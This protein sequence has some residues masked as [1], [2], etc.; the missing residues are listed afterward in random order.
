MSTV[1]FAALGSYVFLATRLP[2]DLPRAEA[3]ARQV[4]VDLDETCSR[5]REDSDLSRV[6]RQAGQWVRVDPMLVAAVRVAVDAARHTDGLVNPLLGRRL[7]EL[8]YDRDLG[9]LDEADD[10]ARPAA[11]PPHGAYDWHRIELADDAIRIPRETALDLGATAKAWGADLIAGAHEQHLRGPALVSL[12]GDIALAGPPDE[13]WSIGVS[14]HPDG[15]VEDLITLTSGGL[16]TSSTRVRRWSR[17]GVRRHHLLDPRTSQPA[18]EVWTTVTATG[19]T[20][21]AA[22][23]ASTA[24]I[25]LG[26]KAPAWLTGR[27]VTARLVGASGP[28]L[29]GGW[30]AACEATSGA[31]SGVPA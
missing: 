25:V 8:G 2:T 1:R 26:A 12:G 28:C 21:V 27:G 31:T 14:T 16:A 9:L 17:H 10:G 6:N 20:C 15:P 29:V 19:P 13:A 11:W 22:N 23:T 18:A 3:L 30:P 4:L 24:A 5:F 7:V